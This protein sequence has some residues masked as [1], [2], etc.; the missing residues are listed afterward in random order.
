M[1]QREHTT[2]ASDSER[3]A[4]RDIPR[5]PIRFWW[6]Y[7]MRHKHLMVFATIAVLG[8]A[9]LVSFINLIYKYF[10]DSIVANDYKL[11]VILVLLYPLAVFLEHIFWRASG[12][13]GMEWVV[14]A[15]RDVYNSMVAYTMRHS[16]GYFINRF[17]GSLL[18]KVDNVAEANNKFIHDYLWQ[19]LDTVVIL[20]V[21]FVLVFRV[22]LIAGILFLALL[23]LLVL[24]NKKLAPKQRKLSRRNAE[25]YTTLRGY[26]VDTFTNIMA[27]RHHASAPYEE[28]KLGGH[29]E[30]S[31]VA[32]KRSWF[33]S[34]MVQVVNN[35]LLFIFAVIIMYILTMRWQA[36]AITPGDLVLVI[37]IFSSIT[38]ILTRLGRSFNE[39]AKAYGK[40]EEGL[41]E[42]IID[43]EITDS[44]ESSKLKLSGGSITF[45]Q[46]NFAYDADH[47]FKKLH[48]EIR[49]GE[50]VGLVGPSGAGKTTLVSLLLRQHEVTDGAILIDGQNIAEVTQDS[51]RNAIAV[52]PQEPLLFHRSIKENIAYAKPRATQKEIEVVAKMAEAHSFIRALPEGYNTLVGERGVKLSGG[53][54]QRIAIARAMLKDAPVLV[55]D[56]ATSALDSESE[57]AIQKALHTLMEG[58]TVLAIAHRLSTLREMDRI[59]VLENGCVVEDGTHEEL[60]RAGGTY[61]RLWEHQAG[62]FLQ[63]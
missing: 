16:H 45:E 58:K 53:Q 31:K 26:I 63:E 62:G 23:V 59:I 54:K 30:D 12:F 46:L 35:V 39:T 60:A 34:E 21:S 4:I 37:A 17:A 36:G 56:E 11:V 42:L 14:R 13:I 7:S 47:V 24:V 61:Q 55:L 19:Y 52:V 44:N 25:T 57:V 6:F 18:S 22:D 48:L 2:R 28:R 20:L 3:I 1:T 38:G 43:H 27:V 51:L 50:R 8:A 10:V 33:Y 49:P 5:T 9:L 40:L 32:H 15:E 29:V 41:S